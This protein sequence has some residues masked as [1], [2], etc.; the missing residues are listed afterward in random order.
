VYRGSPIPAVP[1]PEG[2]RLMGDSNTTKFRKDERQR[3]ASPLAYRNQKDG[4]VD[5][6]VYVIDME[7]NELRYHP[8]AT[9]R[10]STSGTRA[11]IAATKVTSPPSR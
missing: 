6:D 9:M 8:A 2:G 1:K 7:R 5:E 4:I 3:L 10:G 11:H